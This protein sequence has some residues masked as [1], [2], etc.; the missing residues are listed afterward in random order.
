MTTYPKNLQLE[1]FVSSM[2]ICDLCKEQLIKNLYHEDCLKEYLE[3][4]VLSPSNE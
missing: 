3:S 2:K 4:F 1:E